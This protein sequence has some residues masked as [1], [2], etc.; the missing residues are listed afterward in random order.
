MEC[1]SLCLNMQMWVKKV[2]PMFNGEVRDSKNYDK[3]LLNK[4]T[5]LISKCLH[6]G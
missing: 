6:I 4:R 3:N 5:E 2:R 1:R